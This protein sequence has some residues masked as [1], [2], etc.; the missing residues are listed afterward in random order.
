M[1]QLVYHYGGGLSDPGRSGVGLITQS[2]GG[3]LDGRLLYY[4]DDGYRLVAE[5]WTE[6]IEQALEKQEQKPSD[7]SG[8]FL[9]FCRTSQ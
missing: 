1:V 5:S 7:E 8:A 6:L 9:P 4:D 3:R 2:P